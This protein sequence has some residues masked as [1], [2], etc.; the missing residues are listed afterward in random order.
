MKITILS[1]YF[2]P[3]QFLI[4]QLAVD[5]KKKGHEVNVLTGLPNYPKGQFLNGYSF[6]KG[7]YFE[8]YEGV[9]VYRTPIIPRGKGFLQLALNYASFIF[10][11]TSS[12]F[13][14]PKAD[15]YFVYAISPLMSAIPA[16]VFRLFNRTPVVIWLQDLWPES[17]NAVGA[18]E[19][20]SFVYKT[21]GKVV[22][23]IYQNTDFILIQLIF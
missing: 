17:L 19:K 9:P 4:S 10:S 18:F 21:I 3:E 2:H 11:A 14:L 5:L 20:S 6:W 13:R 12:L 15:V 23:W 1:Q 16:L 7:P 22:R 8:T